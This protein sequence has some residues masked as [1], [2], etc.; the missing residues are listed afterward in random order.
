[1][2]CEDELGEVCYELVWSSIDTSPLYLSYLKIKQH[3]TISVWSVLRN[4]LK[5]AG[6]P[7]QGEN[8]WVPYNIRN[9]QTKQNHSPFQKNLV[10]H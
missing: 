5:L 1:M 6:C 4:C 7:F 10:E 3:R 2:I 8:A 9:L